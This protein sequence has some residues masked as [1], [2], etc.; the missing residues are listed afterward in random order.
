METDLH[1]TK[2]LT[3]A[4]TTAWGVNWDE[5]YIARDVMQNFFDA[6]HQ[7]LDEVKVAHFGSSQARR[8]VAISAPNPFNLERLFY[9]GSEKSDDDIGQYGEGFKVAATCLLRDHN[10]SPIA[11]SGQDVVCLRVAENSIADTQLYPVEYDFYRS[12]QSFAGT[13]LLLPGCS[14]KLAQALAQGLAHFFYETNPLIGEKLWMSQDGQFSI[15]AS[16]ERNGHIFYRKLKRGEIEALPIIL[17][18]EKCFERIEKKI[19]KDRDRNAF[20]EEMMK[21]F[22]NHFA[23]YGL[24]HSSDG[25]R[26]VVESAR[27]IWAKGHPLLSEIAEAQPHY[28]HWSRKD[29][30]LVFGDQYYARSNLTHHYSRYVHHNFSDQIEIESIEKEWRNQGKIAV[31]GYFSHFGVISAIAH[32]E[33]T[34]QKAMQE[35]MRKNRRAPTAAEI[36]AIHLLRRIFNELAPDVL[37][38]FD[39]AETTYTVAGTDTLLGALK[40]ERHYQSREVFLAEKVFLADFPD[41]LAIFIHEH[42]HIFGHDGSRSFSDALTNLFAEVVRFRHFLDTYEADW[43]AA[44]E[45][46]MRERQQTFNGNDQDQIQ[47]WLETLDNETLR[48]LMSSLPAGLLN[49]LRGKPLPPEVATRPAPRPSRPV[50]APVQ[51]ASPHYIPPPRLQ[52]PLAVARPITVSLAQEPPAYVEDSV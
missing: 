9:L 35:D 24:K 10:I 20:G 14:N 19:S 37:G 22:Y 3:S 47:A 23:R 34:R 52:R 43:F 31:P 44:R 46:V 40:S 39:R 21:L 12:E 50:A 29:A 6:N 36:E 28:G 48:E 51:A 26:V 30:E 5:V 33:E 4:V 38:F 49:K 45:R 18:I 27:D 41:A 1:Y 42:T 16:R 15:Y 2:T 11:I 13:S 7:C 25:Q 8:D 32:L 17:V